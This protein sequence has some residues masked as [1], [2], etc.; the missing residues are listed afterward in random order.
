MIYGKLNDI[1]Q[2]K[3]LDE[4]YRQLLAL[5]KVDPSEIGAEPKRVE[6]DGDKNYFT[7]LEAATKH[8]DPPR[9]EVHHRAADIHCVYEGIEA[10]YFGDGEGVEPDGEYIAERDVA[11]L[12][13]VKENVCYLHPGEFLLVMPEEVHSPLNASHGC[14]KVKKAVGKIFYK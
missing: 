5:S 6:V 7:L 12:K 3:N 13:G 9:L 2:Y 14:E 10:I 11:F 4:I 1:E 8:L